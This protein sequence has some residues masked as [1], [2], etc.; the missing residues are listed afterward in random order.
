MRIDIIT[1]HE[2]LIKSPF[3]HSIMKRALSK[4]LAEVNF[5]NLRDYSEN[6]HKSVDDY[7]FG[8]GA[9]MVM[10]IEP[11]SKCI[12][13]LKSQ[14]N[15]D[16]IVYLTP[17]GELFN[18]KTANQLSTFNNLML[19]CGHYKGIDERVRELYITRELSIGDYVISGGE[20]AAAIVAD[21]LIRLLPGVLSD[22]TSALSDSF[23]DGL[24]AP[25]AYTRPAEF[26]G[27]K[28]PE[29]L[30]SGNPARIEQ[31]RMEQALERTRK[32]RPDLL[33]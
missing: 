16:E 12:E 4:G 2:D 15:Y 21:A 14:R 29:V 27:L 19:V 8:G 24:L 5:V 32:R 25:P 3:Q 26:K 9:G 20:M 17:D 11:L 30:L 1:I 33:M 22:E 10:M 31:W 6:K 23:Q 13:T 18:Q 28:V 7:Q